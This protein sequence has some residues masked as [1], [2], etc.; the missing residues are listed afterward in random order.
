[1]EAA[2]VRELFKNRNKFTKEKVLV[3]K[4][5]NKKVL[6]GFKMLMITYGPLEKFEVLKR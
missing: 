2:S 3:L 5:F 1:M 6:N 4:Y